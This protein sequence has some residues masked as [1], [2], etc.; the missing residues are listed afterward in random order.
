MDRYSILIRWSDEDAGYIATCPE[1][2][3]L[4]GFGE[5]RSD[6]LREALVLLE[7]YIETYNVDGD[8]L[9]EPDVVRV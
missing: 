2:G 1:F 6:A 7:M 8:T 3:A 9:P 4:S 5:T